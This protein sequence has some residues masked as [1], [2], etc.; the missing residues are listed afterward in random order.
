MWIRVG[1]SRLDEAQRLNYSTLLYLVYN[2]V[3]IKAT[4]PT[5]NVLDLSINESELKR[6]LSDFT[7][8]VFAN[9]EKP[10]REEIAI[11]VLLYGDAHK[12]VRYPVYN[13]RRDDINFKEY[14]A[15]RVACVVCGIL[16]GS[17]KEYQEVSLRADYK[18]KPLDPFSRDQIQAVCP[19]CFSLAKASNSIN[20]VWEIRKERIRR[21]Q[22]LLTKKFFGNMAFTLKENLQYV[23]LPAFSQTMTAFEEAKRFV[24]FIN[25]VILGE[26]IYY[27]INLWSPRERRERDFPHLLMAIMDKS[28]AFEVDGFLLFERRRRGRKW[29]TERIL[30]IKKL[31][32][33]AIRPYILYKRKVKL[34]DDTSRSLAKAIRA[35]VDGDLMSY[36]AIVGGELPHGKGSFIS[37][38]IDPDKWNIKS[39][40]EEIRKALILMSSN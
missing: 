31:I 4:G 37:R 22:Y 19:F 20:G 7:I 17:K 27:Y 33:R 29:S 26:D 28:V 14:E 15:P 36:Y 1:W 10:E 5:R 18:Q 23:V 40:V 6:R 12:S 30:H 39:C 11:P 16:H 21:Y 2:A 34:D 25:S 32:L 9:A 13:F 35:L 8:N 24:D 38:I 3:E